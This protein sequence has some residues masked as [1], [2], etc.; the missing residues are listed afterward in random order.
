[1]FR[2]LIKAADDYDFDQHADQARDDRAAQLRGEKRKADMNEAD[3]DI[4]PT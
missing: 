2:A 1:M 3:R 4:G